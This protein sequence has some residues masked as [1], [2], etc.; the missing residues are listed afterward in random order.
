MQKKEGP[1][2][3]GTLVAVLLLG[4]FILVSWLGVFFLYLSRN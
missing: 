4:A 3:K 2:L 1:S